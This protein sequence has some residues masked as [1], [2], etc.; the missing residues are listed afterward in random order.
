M[1]LGFRLCL[2]VE[3][4]VNG[5]IGKVLC[6]SP[7]AFAVAVAVMCCSWFSE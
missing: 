3:M 4:R 2:L 1:V 5:Q 6:I 7:C